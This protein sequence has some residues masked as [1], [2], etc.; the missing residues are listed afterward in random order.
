MDGS[1]LTLAHSF[2]AAFA[3][4]DNWQTFLAGLA[5]SPGTG[6]SMGFAEALSD[7]GALT[8]R[9]SAVLRGA[10]RGIMAAPGDPGHSLP[11]LVPGS[12]PNSFGSPPGS[13][14]ALSFSNF[15]S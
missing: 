13:R 15:G 14:G 1:V 7:D 5:A 10:I 12:W 6:I 4:H 2:A 9:G 11:Y 8:G 3:T